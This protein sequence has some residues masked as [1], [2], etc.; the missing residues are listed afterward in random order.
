[1]S[2]DIT[3]TEIDGEEYLTTTQAAK[4]FNVSPTTFIGF[5]EDFHLESW[6]F[7]GMGNK[8]FFKKTDLLAIVPQL[9]YRPSKRTK[10]AQ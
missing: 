8:K 9:K 3:G 1:M 7:R 4:F 6:S 5:Q 2:T 10:A